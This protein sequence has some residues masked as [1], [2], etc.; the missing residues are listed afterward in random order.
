[1]V[2]KK[3]YVQRTVCEEGV[4]TSL[5]LP[6]CEKSGSVTI[7]LQS[8]HKACINGNLIID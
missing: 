6:T 7:G 1:M 4:Q 5:S 3:V 8:L 2:L